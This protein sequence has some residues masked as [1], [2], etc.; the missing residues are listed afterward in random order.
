MS[1]RELEFRDGS[2][3][4]FWK[5]TLDGKS[6]TVVFGRRGTNGQSQTKKWT[7]LD[8]AR[9]NHDKLIAEKTKKGYVEKKTK[10]N[11]TAKAALADPRPTAE[12]AVQPTQAVSMSTE[13]RI[14]LAPQDWAIATWRKLAPPKLP[15]PAPFDREACEA[16]LSGLK[17]GGRDNKVP[18]W[19]SVGLPEVMSREEAHY[20]FLAM[21][22][23]NQKERAATLAK[24][25]LDGRVTP[26]DVE[27][28]IKRVKELIVRVAIRERPETALVLSHLLSPAQLADWLLDGQLRADRPVYWETDFLDSYRR[29]IAPYI[30][31]ADVEKFRAQLR[32]LITVDKFAPDPWGGAGLF[33]IAAA[34]GMRDELH[35]VVE[36]WKD[37]R[38]AKNHPTDLHQ[39]PI[40]IVFGLGDPALVE[41]HV[42]RL[43]LLLRTPQH[44]AG[45]LAH[46][47]WRALDVVTESI[48][49]SLN[50]KECEELIAAFTVVKAPEAAGPMLQLSLKAKSPKGARA[51]LDENVGHAAPGLAAVAASRGPLADAAAAELRDLQRKGVSI[52]AVKDLPA[53]QKR[54]PARS[55]FDAKTTPA[56]LAKGVTGAARLK[57]PTWIKSGGLPPLAAD[58]RQ[59]SDDQVAAVLAALQASTLDKPHPLVADLRKHADPAVADEFAWRLFERWLGDGASGKEKWAM[60]ALGQLGGDPTVLKLTP[61]VR[62]WP[63]ESQHA[64]AVLG[65]EVL[66]A[67]GS[68]TA[69]MQL[70]GI[71]QKL[72][73]QALKVKARE[74]M[75]DI[76]RDKGMSRGELED[77]MVPDFDLDE[78]G[79]RV[80][81]YGARRFTFV[82]G[83]GL[84]PMVR[85]DD[86]KGKLRD[87]LPDAGPKDDADKAAAAIAE[88]TAIKKQIKDVA[89]LQADRLEQAMVTGRRWKTAD[90]QTLVV[91]HPLMTHLARLLVW[92][93]YDGKKLR[94]TFR[95]T[96]DQELMNVDDETVELGADSAIGLVHPLQL[97]EA[98]R[99]AWGQRFADYAIIPP[100][101]QLGRAVH[102]L[103]K[104]EDKKTS[105]DRF[106]KLKL[107]AP[108]LVFT[109]EKLGWARGKPM[110]AGVFDEHSR[111]FPAA[112]V[113]ALVTYEGTVGMG[114]ISPD[115]QLTITGCAFVDGLRAPSGYG[116]RE[117][118]LKL[119]DV[120]PIVFS[121]TVHDLTVVASKAKS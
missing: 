90:F 83:P 50:K 8:E 43:R 120:D 1:T 89:K 104:G 101:P 11:G 47:E 95:V 20:W 4:K 73:F 85:D 100:F 7:S 57:A 29:W 67:I 93:L 9:K 12:E 31:D 81:D 119:G 44:V 55:S 66:R 3:D 38:Y 80:F 14:D 49:K 84:K 114:Y 19:S 108:S 48:L 79:R 118:R 25:K 63:G 26:G 53:E 24:A 65:L 58:G 91:R 74:F 2:S 39:H 45:W 105:L 99:E 62:A 75:D 76:A 64:R 112:K 106:D 109:L 110:D 51:W 13:R 117:K 92:G 34:L 22:A 16:K 111:Q 71:A 46:T 98:A 94:D 88:W 23:N 37:D 72:K 59:L 69:L 113:T 30:L 103:E 96:E 5:I 42:R 68:D 107:P 27:A 60:A 21:T 86:D 70:N 15:S 17:Y 61:L 52:G 77:R 54:A 35:P 32:P 33:E 102:R 6:T 116:S 18:D 115:E 121:E 82:L 41:K 28:G 36:S 78:R 56:W 87:N 10:A 40:V 97:G